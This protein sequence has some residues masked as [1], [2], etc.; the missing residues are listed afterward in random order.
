MTSLNSID[1]IKNIL[2][3]NLES[4]PD[5]KKHMEN[6]LSILGINAQRFNAIKMQNG[7]LGCSLSHLRCIEL[8]K[9]NEWDHILIMEDDIKFLEPDLFKQQFNKFLKNHKEFDVCLI[10][11]NNYSPYKVIDNSCV[12]VTKCQTTTGYLV[13]SHYYDTLIENYKLGIENLMR[14]PSKE[15]S[16]AIDVYWFALQNKDKWY[17]I[18]PL[19]VIQREDYSDIQK[20]SINY[21]YAMINLE[22]KQSKWRMFFK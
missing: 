8:A 5:R 14:D 7:A 20:R 16:Y 3:I 15:S 19:T 22:K 12:K 21:T 18:T 9:K 10:A 4:R 2:Y 11:G 1:D 6:Q 17:L 13:K